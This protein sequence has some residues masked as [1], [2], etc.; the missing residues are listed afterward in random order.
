MKHNYVLYKK[1]EGVGMPMPEEAILTLL[2]HLVIV[3]KH[4]SH[5]GSDKMM[6]HYFEFK[7]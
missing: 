1:N 3:H 2:S 6:N 5:V 4:S 7:D